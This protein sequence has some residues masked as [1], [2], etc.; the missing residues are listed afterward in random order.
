MWY[1]W[2]LHFKFTQFFLLVVARLLWFLFDEFVGERLQ[3]NEVVQTR[4]IVHLALLVRKRQV[5]FDT[6]GVRAINHGVVE[7]CRL[8]L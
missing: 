4:G 6:A 1:L 2:Q 7:C 5:T 3:I 8:L